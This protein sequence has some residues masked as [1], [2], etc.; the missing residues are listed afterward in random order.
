M[1]WVEKLRTSHAPVV[2]AFSI[3]DAAGR[4]SVHGALL[5]LVTRFNRAKDGTML[6]NAEYLEVVIRRR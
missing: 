6:V 1:D 2:R 4:K 3:Q 5:E